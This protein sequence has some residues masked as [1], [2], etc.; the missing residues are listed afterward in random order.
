[1][2]VSVVQT[3]YNLVFQ[4][5]LKTSD[6]EIKKLKSDNIEKEKWLKIEYDAGVKTIRD[7]LEEEQKYLSEKIFSL[8]K[9]YKNLENFYREQVETNSV[10]MG[11]LS[12]QQ[13][14]N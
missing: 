3:F 4:K 13:K 14:I 11:E 5:I 8:N 10:L 2:I 9:S 7:K 12:R 1:M 6:T